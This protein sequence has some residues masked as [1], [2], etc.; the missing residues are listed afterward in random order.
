MK[1]SIISRDVLRE[2]TSLESAQAV[3]CIE[4]D[5]NRRCDVVAK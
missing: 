1:E 5:N 2:Q 4:N 3:V